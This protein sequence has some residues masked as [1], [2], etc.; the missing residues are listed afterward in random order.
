MIKP[1]LKT[2][3][4]LLG[5]HHLQSTNKNTRYVDASRA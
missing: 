5:L 2:L 1:S 4:Y 3:P